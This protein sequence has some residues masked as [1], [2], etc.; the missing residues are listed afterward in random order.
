MDFGAGQQMTTK[1][2]SVL[3]DIGTYVAIFAERMA[4]MMLASIAAAT[5]SRRATK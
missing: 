5:K 4:G 3:E 1:G 2:M